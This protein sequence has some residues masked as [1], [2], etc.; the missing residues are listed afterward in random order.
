MKLF[1]GGGASL[2]AASKNCNEYK[3][4]RKEEKKEKK[5]MLK[6]TSI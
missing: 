1:D 5:E 2:K 3:G 6:R 4:Q